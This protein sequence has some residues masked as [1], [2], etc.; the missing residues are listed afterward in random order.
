MKNFDHL[1]FFFSYLK[2]TDS[3]DGRRGHSSSCNR[4]A[5]DRRFAPLPLMH[6]G[7]N[8]ATEIAFQLLQKRP[9][10]RQRSKLKLRSKPRQQRSLQRQK[11][12]RKR[13]KRRSQQREK[14]VRGCI[15]TGQLQC[16]GYIY[17]MI[18]SM[19]SRQ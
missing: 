5:Q 16:L 18:V 10:L 9:S 13:R 2:F 8:V 15:N 7:V 6:G 14:E 11:K 19:S 1:W 4:R 12:Q 17:C 3:Q